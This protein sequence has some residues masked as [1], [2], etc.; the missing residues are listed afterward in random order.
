[1]HKKECIKCGR[2]LTFDEIAL[3]RKLLGKSLTEHMCIIC[4]AGHFN[5]TEELLHEKIVQFKE[6]G[7]LLFAENNPYENA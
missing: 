4:M 5:V 7:C 3:H 1:M 2:N 6:M